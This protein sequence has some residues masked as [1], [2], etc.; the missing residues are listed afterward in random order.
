[1]SV[2]KMKIMGIIGP[3]NI[4]NKVLRVVILNGSMHMINALSRVNSAD[5]FLPPT[6]KN[7]TALEEIPF[8]KSYSQKRDLAEDEKMVNLF[9]ELF[10]IKPGLKREYLSEDY[11][12]DDFMKQF[13]D[14]YSQVLATTFEIEEKS[15][16]IDKKREYLNNL[17]YLTKFNLDISR[18]RNMKYLVFRL[19]KITRENYDKLKKNYENIPA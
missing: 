12:Y 3:Q 10:D 9:Q 2:E 17:K 4:L 18:L 11:N 7:I 16:E 19:I 1:M 5:F 14:L 6:E 13:S 8:L 15:R